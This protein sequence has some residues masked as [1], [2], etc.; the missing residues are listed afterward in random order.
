MMFIYEKAAGALNKML[1]KMRT[2]HQ[3]VRGR[4]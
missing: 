4:V 3:R 1:R 2:N